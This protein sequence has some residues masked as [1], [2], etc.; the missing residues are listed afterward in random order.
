MS[1]CSIGYDLLRL[2]DR[3]AREAG[4]IHSKDI[5]VYEVELLHTDSVNPP[6]V[7][8]ILNSSYFFS[9]SMLLSQ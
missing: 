1:Q 6:Q 4:S 7:T 9:L 5:Y 2:T 8:L 3:I